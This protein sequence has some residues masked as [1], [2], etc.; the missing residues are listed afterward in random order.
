MKKILSLILVAALA[1]TC[2]GLM[3]GC[4]DNGGSTAS[5]GD[6]DAGTIPSD[7]KIGLICLH[8]KNSTYD[9]N[10][11]VAMEKVQE[12]LGLSDDQVIIATGIPEGAEC[13]DKAVEMAEAG[14]KVI[15]ADSFGHEQYMMEAA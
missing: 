7:F 8:D 6:T 11:I 1:L 9:K 13:K 10:F 5:T 3:A 15:M 14:C 2:I 12:E 4:S